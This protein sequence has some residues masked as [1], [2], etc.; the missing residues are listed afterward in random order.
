MQLHHGTFEAIITDILEN[1]MIAPSYWGTKETAGEYGDG[2]CLDVDL[3]AFDP[4]LI[5]PNDLLIEALREADD[6]DAGVLEW[7]ASEGTWEDSLRIFG[8]VRYDGVL[9]VEESWI[10]RPEP[11]HCTPA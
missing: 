9:A 1:G 3:D 2:A 10:S 11:M 6:E 8:S 7:D 5:M 4:D